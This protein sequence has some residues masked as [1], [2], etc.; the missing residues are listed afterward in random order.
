M[1]DSRGREILPAGRLGPARPAIKGSLAL[2][3][4]DMERQAGVLRTL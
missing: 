3:L 2:Q 1:G 4:R